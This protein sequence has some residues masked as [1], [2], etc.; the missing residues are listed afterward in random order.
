MER[1][2]LVFIVLLSLPSVSPAV[3]ASSLSTSIHTTAVFNTASANQQ[4]TLTSTQNTTSIK[5]P[6]PP[7][8][9]IPHYCFPYFKQIDQFPRGIKVRSKNT[10]HLNTASHHSE[11]TSGVLECDTAG[12]EQPNQVVATSS[13]VLTTA[14]TVEQPSDYICS[15][16]AATRNA[17]EG[18]QYALPNEMRGAM[19]SELVESN[20]YASVP[21]FPLSLKHQQQ[22]TT[23]HIDTLPSSNHGN[24]LV[25]PED[26]AHSQEMSSKQPSDYICSVSAASR[27]AQELV[28]SN[29]YASVPAFPLSLKHQQQPTTKHVEDY[30][31]AAS[32][33][34]TISPPPI[35]HID[36]L[37]SNNHGNALLQSEDLAYSQEM[38]SE[39]PSDYICSV[40]AAS[41]NARE[42][43]LP[44][45]IRGTRDTELVESNGYASVPAFPLSLKHQQQPTTK[46][47]VESNGY[48]SV[49]AFPLSL[50]HQQQPTTKHQP[51]DYICSVSA[52]SRNA[53]EGCLPNEIRGTMDTEL[54]ELNGYVSAHAFEL[55]F[56]LQQQPTI[57]HAQEYLYATNTQN[58]SP[59]STLHPP[60][61]T[62]MND[63]LSSSNHG[64]TLV[65]SEDLTSSQEFSFKSVCYI[66]DHKQRTTE[67]EPYSKHQEE[68]NIIAEKNSKSIDNDEAF[69]QPA[70]DEWDLYAQFKKIKVKLLHQSIIKMSNILGS[71][72]FGTVNRGVWETANGSV[73]VAIK[74]LNPEKAGVDKNKIKFLREVAIMGQ[75][76]HPNVVTLHGIVTE[77]GTMMMVLELLEKGDLQRCLASRTPD[78]KSPSSYDGLPQNL[79]K[80]C[81]HIASG[82]EYLAEKG[83]IH[84]DLAARNIL[85]SDHDIC[86]IAD[87]G[88]SRDLEDDTYYISKGGKI[89]LRWTA[90]EALQYKK[91]STASDVWSYGCVMYE[92]WSMGEKLYKNHSNYNILKIVESG[93]RIPP[94][95]GCPRSIYKIMI[96][97]WHPLENNRPSFTSIK[98]SL[99]TPEETLLKWTD[100]DLQVHPQA[101]IIKAPLE[102]AAGLYEDLQKKYI[103]L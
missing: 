20:D 14:R 15:V 61:S 53:Q 17:R 45:E 98:Q 22:P 80:Y 50:K 54:V 13:I 33:Q 10:V 28:E 8:D 91:Y 5:R 102:A 40:S 34:N 55:S 43:C 71:G 94:P 21:A 30:L 47:L 41:R 70:T 3:S 95:P 16:S 97:C 1:C 93:Y 18:C 48:A 69:L 65:Q 84:R 26:L 59:P 78:P 100:A 77:G 36:T 37:P 31:Y 4:T 12:T 88:M 83:F 101:S 57:K 86:K 85:V 25:Q 67:T 44:N 66:N 23:K 90:P 87:F 79:L 92:I 29:G 74:V 103:C 19:G 2:Y 75:F 27:N 49:P 32:T 42:G 46:H 52:A 39:Q 62:N 35:N 60:P 96:E 51:S 73:P 89:P 56:N 64:N 63:T 38:S 24:T 9:V 72:Q 99:L 6:C 7:H 82:M 11:V 76:C 68:M 81:Q 58:G